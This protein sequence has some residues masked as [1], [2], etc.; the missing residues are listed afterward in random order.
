[1]SG[2]QSTL[3]ANQSGGYFALL[4]SFYILELEAIGYLN[5]NT[6]ATLQLKTTINQLNCN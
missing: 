3:G 5:I 1:M 4:Y 6:G 2:I